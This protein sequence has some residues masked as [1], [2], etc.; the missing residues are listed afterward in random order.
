MMHIIIF[1]VLEV[2]LAPEV[3][4]AG[5]K[6]LSKLS[7]LQQ[8]LFGD[9]KES[10]EFQQKCLLLCAQFLPKLRIAGFNFA[11]AYSL[12]MLNS[13]VDGEVGDFYHDQV[14]QH[15]FKIGLEELMVSGNVQ[16][17]ESCQL[18]NLRALYTSQLTDG[19]IAGLFSRFTT[20]TELG[21]C[22]TKTDTV[23]NVLQIVGRSLS[24]IALVQLPQKFSLLKIFQLCP[25][26]ERLHIIVCKFNDSDSLWPME[27][28]GCLEEVN[29]QM[30]FD[31]PL[32]RGFIVKVKIKIINLHSP[33]PPNFLSTNTQIPSNIMTNSDKIQILVN[34]YSY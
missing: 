19:N 12:D 28:L 8:F 16:I 33:I 22:K 14:V 31:E 7:H 2:A 10:W 21:I 5:F 3:S 30:I 17:H 24:K 13:M 34:L 26:L 6:A 9:F 23:M 11:D 27:I 15:P 20:I 29:F 25:N 4:S 18:P 1:R 32:P